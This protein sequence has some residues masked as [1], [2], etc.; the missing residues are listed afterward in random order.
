MRKVLFLTLITALALGSCKSSKKASTSPYTQ[1]AQQESTTPAPKVFTVPETKPAAPAVSDEKPV[2]MR[3]EAITFTRPEE[4]NQ[5]SYF[6]IIGSFSNMN[7]AMNYKQ[8]LISE[9]FTPII[10]QSETGYYRVTVDSYANE[11]P[12]RQRLLQIRQN[13][14]KYADTW[15]L[16]K[17]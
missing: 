15:L 10:V 9:G 3:E 13:Y 1:A 7:N 16:I 14:P 5:N 11:A 4:Q 17:K 12:A 8:T 2:T 6:I